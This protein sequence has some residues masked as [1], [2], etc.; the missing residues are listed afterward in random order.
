M[1]RNK[2]IWY[3]HIVTKNSKGNTVK[4]FHSNIYNEY[5]YVVK[6][7]NGLEVNTG[8]AYE[9]LENALASTEK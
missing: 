3:K 7:I 1:G 5:S 4:I 6:E 9:T 2:S 8:L